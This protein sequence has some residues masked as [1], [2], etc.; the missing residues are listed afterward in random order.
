MC[1]CIRT[2]PLSR[3]IDGP[4]IAIY[5][6]MHDAL[7]KV[8]AWDVFVDTCEKAF[9]AARREASVATRLAVGVFSKFGFDPH[10]V[11]DYITGPSSLNTHEPI[12]LVAAA[13]VR[14]LVKN[15]SQNWKTKFKSYSHDKID[16]AF[17]SMLQARFPPAVFAM[18]IVDSKHASSSKKLQDQLTSSA[19]SLDASSTSISAGDSRGRIASFAED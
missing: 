6:E 3:P 2:Q 8:G 7:E 13:K 16:P 17:Y 18:K 11:R 15:S 19:I 10:R 4:Q 5:P 14:N 12:E 1:F 9:L